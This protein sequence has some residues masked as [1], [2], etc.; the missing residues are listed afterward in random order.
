MERPKKLICLV[1][2]E[3]EAMGFILKRVLLS[4]SFLFLLVIVL[5]DLL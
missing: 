5:L 4:L 1:F 2:E 3:V